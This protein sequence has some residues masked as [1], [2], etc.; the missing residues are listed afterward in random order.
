LITQQ[1]VQ[2]IEKALKKAQQKGEL[3]R[4]D[5]PPIGLERPKDPTHGDYATPAAL[6]MARF[7]RMAPI[8]IAEKI[9]NRLEPAD[10]LGQVS[11][12]PPGFINIRLS[13]SWL[14]RQVEMILAE[15]DNF[16][17]V[18]LGR[19][20]KVQVEFI[21]ANPTGPLTIGSGRNAGFESGVAEFHRIFV[22]FSRRRALR[23]G[24][25]IGGKSPKLPVPLS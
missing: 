12:A 9:V 24:C 5:P 19:G 25:K 7:A 11:V 15:G 14:A 13:E 2:L 17:R 22:S 18:S 16:G 20:Q 23:S 4:F 10:Y 3:P 8:Q 6:G 1:I 21:S